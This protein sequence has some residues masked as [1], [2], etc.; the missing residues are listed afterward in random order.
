[1]K[2]N[3]GSS[4]VDGIKI[5]DVEAMG[6]EKYLSEIVFECQ[7]VQDIGRNTRKIKVDKTVYILEKLGFK[8]A[9]V[10]KKEFMSAYKKIK[11]L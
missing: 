10:G 7:I 11:K 9:P 4:G 1:M 3:K 6:I 8:W 2:A 5:E